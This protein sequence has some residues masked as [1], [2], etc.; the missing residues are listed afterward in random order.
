MAGACVSLKTEN[1]TKVSEPPSSR[2]LGTG[3]FNVPAEL[4]AHR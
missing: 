1:K 3:Q 2:L 4:V